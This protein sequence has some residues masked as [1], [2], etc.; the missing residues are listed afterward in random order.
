[1]WLHLISWYTTT[2]GEGCIEGYVPPKLLPLAL[3]WE[4]WQYDIQRVA[5]AHLQA[6]VHD[7]DEK[8]RSLLI[9]HGIARLPTS[10]KEHSDDK[11]AAVILL[12][13]LGFVHKKALDRDT[14]KLVASTLMEI[15]KSETASIKHRAAAAEVLSRAY[16][17]FEPFCDLSS[18]FVSRS[19]GFGCVCVTVKVRLSFRSLVFLLESVTLYLLF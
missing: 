9:H 4:H 16:A 13:V 12:G 7:L 11:I 17:I 5:R 10:T 6:R 3:I 8:G 18:V 2:W 1:M 14:A 15:V 19:F